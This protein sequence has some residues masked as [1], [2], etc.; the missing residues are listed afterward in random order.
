M[1][2]EGDEDEG[3]RNVKGEEEVAGNAGC[4]EVDE[5][6]DNEEVCSGEEDEEEEENSDKKGDE[7]HE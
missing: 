5:G 1:R 2:E 4:S 3:E 6:R 7:E